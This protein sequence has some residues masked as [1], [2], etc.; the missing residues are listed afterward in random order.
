MATITVAATRELIVGLNNL[1]KET[2]TAGK[3]IGNTAVRVKAFL[4]DLE[5]ALEVAEKEAQDGAKP[6]G[7]K[8][9]RFNRAACYGSPS[10]TVGPKRMDRAAGSSPLLD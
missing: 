2:V 4:R 6:T 5:T 10:R 3:V 1:W 8:T 7:T 9:T